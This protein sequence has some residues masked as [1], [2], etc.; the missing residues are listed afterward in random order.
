MSV[1]QAGAAALHLEPPAHGS[2]TVHQ[3]IIKPITA[4]TTCY[5]SLCRKNS[6]DLHSDERTGIFRWRVARNIVGSLQTNS[7]NRRLCYFMTAFHS[8]SADKMENPTDCLHK[9]QWIFIFFRIIVDHTF[10]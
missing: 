8:K 3:H 2:L 7:D 4:L 1:E 10:Y 5:M 9:R 6:I